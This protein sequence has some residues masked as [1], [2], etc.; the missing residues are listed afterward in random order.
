MPQRAASYISYGETNCTYDTE[1]DFVDKTD[2]T[3]MKN[4]VTKALKFESI[5]G[6]ANW[7]TATEGFRIIIRRTSFE[8][9]V[10]ELAGMA[11]LI[12]ARVTARNIGLVGADAY[13]IECKSPV[14]IT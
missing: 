5:K 6:G 14:S 8:T 12:M 2:Y 7:A 10:V 1:L 4:N 11:D 3:N 13:T 9:Y